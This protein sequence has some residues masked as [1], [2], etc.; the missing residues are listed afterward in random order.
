MDAHWHGLGALVPSWVLAVVGVGTLILSH[1]E[2]G[3]TRTA[4]VLVALMMIG[5]VCWRAWKL[6]GQAIRRTDAVDRVVEV[7]VPRLITDVASLRSGL[8]ELRVSHERDAAGIHEGQADIKR[9][10]HEIEQR[11]KQRREGDL[12]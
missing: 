4:A 9:Y 1:L 8:D 3:V 6:I 11:S 5:T 7:E 12:P 2:T 10:L